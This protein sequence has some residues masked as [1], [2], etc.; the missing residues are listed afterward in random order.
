[1]R[2]LLLLI[3]AFGLIP[4]TATFNVARA[5]DFGSTSLALIVNPLRS[6]SITCFLLDIIQILLILAV[7]IIVF[8]IIY[9]GFKFVVAQGNETELI[10]AKRALFGALIGGLLI[11][12]AS[13][14]LEVIAG[15]V[16]NFLADDQLSGARRSCR[17]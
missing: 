3:T 5:R 7:P 4:L 10:A 11:L 6:D 9:A 14:I 12:G 16:S 1:M 13:V 2:N 17:L 8:F 15:T